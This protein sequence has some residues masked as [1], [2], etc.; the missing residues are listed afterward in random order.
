LI[1][2]GNE[3]GEPRETFQVLL[4]VTIRVGYEWDLIVA[5]DND[6]AGR[7]RFEVANQLLTPG[8]GRPG[9]NQRQIRN[10]SSG[11]ATLGQEIDQRFAAPDKNIVGRRGARP[12]I[13]DHVELVGEVRNGLRPRV[14]AIKS[15]TITSPLS[16]H[17]VMRPQVHDLGGQGPINHIGEQDP[18]QPPCQ[19]PPAL[20]ELSRQGSKSVEQLQAQIAP[21]HGQEGIA[22]LKGV[23]VKAH[24]HDQ[25]EIARESSEEDRQKALELPLL[26]GDSQSHRRGSLRP[27]AQYGRRSHQRSEPVVW[28]TLER[29]RRVAR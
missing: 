14:V 20:R 8:V 12:Q 22:G 2:A 10:E 24:L 15:V 26:P 27:R 17:L 28:R 7:R 18:H 3:A 16:K 6:E 13:S 1:A 9:R 4:G 11:G 23:G 5:R 25:R 19:T 21:Y 29:H